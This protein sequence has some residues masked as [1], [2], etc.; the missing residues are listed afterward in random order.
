MRMLFTHR[1]VPFTNNIKMKSSFL[2]LF[3]GAAVL[4]VAVKI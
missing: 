3:R 1:N 2:K 4:D